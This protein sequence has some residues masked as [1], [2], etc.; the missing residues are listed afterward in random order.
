M[1]SEHSLKEG[2]AIKVG[3]EKFDL[4]LNIMVGIKKSISSLVD[5]SCLVT[6]TEAH[7]TSKN[8]MEN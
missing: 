3:D 8:K 1:P 6:L 2:Q 5:I 4:I 7:F